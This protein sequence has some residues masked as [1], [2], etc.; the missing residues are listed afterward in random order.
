MNRLLLSICI[1]T[2]NRATF[3]GECLESLARLDT[4]YWG[5]V[6]VIVSDN[7]STDNTV[8]VVDRYRQSIPIRYFRNESNIGGERNFFAAASH[9]SAEHVWVFGDDD[10]FEEAAIVSALKHIRLGYDL[11]VLNY[12][13]WS[14][15]MDAKLNSRGLAR[16]KPSTYDDPNAVLASLGSHL[17]YISCIIVRKEMYLSVPPEEYEQF[18]QYGFSHLYAIY[19][20]IR[21][22]C[23]AVCLPDP[24]FK[25]RADNCLIF[26]GESANSNW[27][28][29]FI[30]GT[31]LVF[32][33]LG[34][35]GYSSLAV[36]RAKNQV[37]RDFVT[38]KILTG[39]NDIS[40][41]SLA[42]LMFRY[43]RWNWRFWTICLPALLIPKRFL[44]FARD[45]Y[46][47][48][49]QHVHSYRRT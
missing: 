18:V 46:L 31:A 27:I 36:L 26:T 12:S 4:G 32:E 15:E 28:T 5:D 29:Y 48:T 23:R 43:Y 33:T 2:Y 40:R 44:S 6:E 7:A 42:R 10:I 13:T 20:G 35:N 14:L 25:N 47:A 21:P 49:R 41:P 24:V 1:P 9:G 39:M 45:L 22:G 38:R 8:E 17:G 30:T 37:L 19:C 16:T 34:R 3:L 11:I